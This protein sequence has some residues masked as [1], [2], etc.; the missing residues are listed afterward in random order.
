MENVQN[1][2][3]VRLDEIG[4]YIRTIQA[5][6]KPK[7]TQEMADL[8]TEFFNVI[9]LVEDIEHYELLH[10]EEELVR[11]RASLNSPEVDWELESRRAEYFSK[12]NR[13]NPFY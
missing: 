3:R 4:V 12:I 8:I 10:H 11:H 6:Y 5:D 1:K 2:P 7:T 9:C 13:S